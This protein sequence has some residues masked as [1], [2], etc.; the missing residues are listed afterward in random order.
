MTAERFA[1]NFATTLTS[2]ISSTSSTSISVAN[3]APVALQDGQ[4]RVRIDDEILLVTAT[5]ASGATPWTVVR[6]AEGSTP[7]THSNG[8]TVKHILTRESLAAAAR[9]E[10]T[11]LPFAPLETPGLVSWYRADT[12]PG[13]DGDKVSVLRDLGPFGAH[14]VQGDTAKQPLLKKNI[15]GGR[16]VMRFDGTNDF[17]Q[18]VAI[19]QR[20]LRPITVFAVV[21]GSGV[22]YFAGAD[23][24]VRFGQDSNGPNIYCGTGVSSPGGSASFGTWYVFQTEYDTTNARINVNGTQV[25]N[26]AE[27][28]NTMGDGWVVGASDNTPTQPWSGDIAEILLCAGTVLTSGQLAVV[29]LGLEAYYGITGT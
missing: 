23:S 6:G 17:L 27:G 11:P 24:L 28:N 12:H 7:A 25:A 18:T 3:S 4:F 14:L 29:R 19:R 16:S 13:A 10:A 1:N 5:G 8:A 20:L 21:K 26:A 22:R 2:A 9:G 15:I